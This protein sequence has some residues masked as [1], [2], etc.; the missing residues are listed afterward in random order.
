ME[1][2]PEE[3]KLN[4][5]EEK[6]VL[7]GANGVGGEKLE[8]LK[9]MLNSLVIELR[10]SGEGGGILNDHAGA[11]YVQKEKVLPNG[12][13]P[14]DTGLRYFLTHYNMEVPYYCFQNFH[15]SLVIQ[16]Q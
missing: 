9:K 16:F 14:D 11:D 10:N 8:V 4:K 2:I 3:S 1:L 6:L 5:C 12:F 7:D 13:T 15:I